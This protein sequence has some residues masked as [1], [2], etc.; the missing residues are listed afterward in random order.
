MRF[1]F[2]HGK[3]YVANVGSVGQPR[4]RNNKA[5]YVTFDGMT[6]QYHRL[7]YDFQKTA[8]KIRT[9]AQLDDRNAERL[10]TGC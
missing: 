10:E 9:I 7:E 8:D 6:L 3:R 5:C 2:E 1:T 4:D